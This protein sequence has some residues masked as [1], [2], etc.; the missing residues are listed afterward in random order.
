MEKYHGEKSRYYGGSSNTGIYFLWSNI[1]S[2]NVLYGKE[3]HLDAINTRPAK[4]FAFFSE[5]G[6][7]NFLKWHILS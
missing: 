6:A 3:Y 5:R 4:D 7:V 1:S 2:L